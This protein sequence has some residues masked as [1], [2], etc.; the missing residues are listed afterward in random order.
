MNILYLLIFVSLILAL[1]GVLFFVYSVRNEDFD[2]G[3]Q[4]SLKPLEDDR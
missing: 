4:L 1:G 3:T 2:H